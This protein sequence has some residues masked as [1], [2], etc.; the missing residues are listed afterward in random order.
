MKSFI[1]PSGTVINGVTSTGPVIMP[2]AVFQ[3]KI[4]L[5][6]VADNSLVISDGVATGVVV[7][8]PSLAAAQSLMQQINNFLES[9]SDGAVAATFPAS[10]TW[11][12]PVNPAT[13]TAGVQFTAVISGSGFD[14]LV[15]LLFKLDDGS[16]DVV[17]NAEVLIVDNSTI[18]LGLLTLP[19]SSKTYTISYSTDGGGVWKST[20][21][22]IST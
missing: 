21:L 1:L 16:G 14:S 15:W 11:T 7:P 19:V 18:N 22:T 6:N 9:S 2:P 3:G 10:V 13:A 20:G 17:D 12:P 4:M 8:T 5:V